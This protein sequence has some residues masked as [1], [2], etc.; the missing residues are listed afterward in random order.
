MKRRVAVTGMG[1]VTPLGADIETVC[2]EEGIAC[3]AIPPQAENDPSQINWDG[4][5]EF[6]KELLPLII[7]FLKAIMIIF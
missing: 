5:L 7:E 1:W 3:G 4:L 6:L 2:I